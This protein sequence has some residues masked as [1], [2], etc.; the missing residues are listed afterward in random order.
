MSKRLRVLL[1]V[2]VLVVLVVTIILGAIGLVILQ[3]LEGWQEGMSVMNHPQGRVEA[4]VFILL[5]CSAAL[6]LPFSLSRRNRWT[7]LVFVALV[8][9]MATIAYGALST[10]MLTVQKGEGRALVDLNNVVA[11]VGDW[12]VI[13]WGRSARVVAYPIAKEVSGSYRSGKQ[14]IKV[15]LAY[16]C[17]PDTR[18][19]NCWYRFCHLGGFSAQDFVSW[20]LDRAVHDCL[21]EMA[22]ASQA[23]QAG[24]LTDQV[25]AQLQA[26]LSR[27]GLQVNNLRFEVV[28]Y[29]LG[30]E[31]YASA[32]S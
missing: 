2:L 5:L 29:P 10:R 22:G 20:Q 24:Q 25:S 14:L 27:R 26:P 32:G 6:L 1:R 3:D 9:G 30:L 31:S 11:F 12:D 21:S 13:G 16:G 8:V 18:A 17:P 7:I 28:A 15:Q 4:F 23:D 19:V